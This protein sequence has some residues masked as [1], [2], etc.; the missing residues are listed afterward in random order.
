MR[1]R[2]TC[3]EIENTELAEKYL[4]GRLSPDEQEAYEDHYFRC[5]RCFDDL[6]LRQGMQAELSEMADPRTVSLRSR[7]PLGWSVWAVAAAILIAVAAAGFWRILRTPGTRVAPVIAQQTPP[8]DSPLELLARVDPPPFTAPALRGSTTIDPRFRDAMKQY[9]QGHFAEAIPG[10]VSAAQ[11]D[12]KSADAQFFL[13]ICYL[14]TGQT[15]EAARRLRT[16]IGLG[17]TLDLELSHFYLAKALL[18]E[19]D[20]SQAEAELESVV[21]MHA[22]LGRPAADLLQKLKS[23]SR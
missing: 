8:A 9:Q 11:A 21:A 18:R 4:L 22:D 7:P 13:G 12:P 1:L 16:T 2:L 10:L 6:Q 23:P 20:V 17:R 5:S 14:M 3:E 15:E 19:K